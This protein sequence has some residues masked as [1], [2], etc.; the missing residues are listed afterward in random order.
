[1]QNTWLKLNFAAVALMMVLLAAAIA[2][3]S[4]ADGGALEPGGPP[5]PG[6]KSLQ[7]VEPRTPISSIPY[8]INASGSYYLTADLSVATDISGITVIVPG[9]TIDLNGF[10][11]TGPPGADTSIGVLGTTL[12]DVINGRITGWS[13]GIITQGGL[14]EDVEVR[15]NDVG[16]QLNGGLARNV[17]AVSNTVGMSIGSDYATIV[18]SVVTGNGTGINVTEDFVR[19]ENSTISNNTTNG[20]AIDGDGLVVRNNVIKKNATGVGWISGASPVIEG[21]T[22]GNNSAYAVY[23]PNAVNATVVKNLLQSN[24]L[25]MAGGN[26]GPV[27][28]PAAVTNPWS[29]VNY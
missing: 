1:M 9:A 10:T 23:L 28:N 8:T 4:F 22:I 24:L 6:M 16:L 21:N 12:V 19:I 13:S 27:E 20:I 3:G 18:D 7:E 15:S 26:Y 25:L 2:R 11:M 5:A 17:R 29:N 14:V